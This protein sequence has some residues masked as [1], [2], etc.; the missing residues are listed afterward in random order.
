MDRDTCGKRN[1]LLV[2]K[3]DSAHLVTVTDS[4]A[5]KLQDQSKYLG[6][7]I[8]AY[9]RPLE[10]GDLLLVKMK[11]K[12]LLKIQSL[13]K[14]LRTQAIRSESGVVACNHSFLSPRLFF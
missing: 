9:T 4:A 6:R 1:L 10:E 8:H 11:E 13:P 2:K 7:H 14:V 12:K 3:K 5:Y